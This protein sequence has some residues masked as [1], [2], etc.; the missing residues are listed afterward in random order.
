MYHGL[1][2]ATNKASAEERAAAPHH[3][4]DELDTDGPWTVIDFHRAAVQR[5]AAI[6][7][8]GKTPVLVGGTHYYLE[9]LLF[10]TLVAA[11]GE[12][13]GEGEG[14]GGGEGGR[15]IVQA[16]AEEARAPPAHPALLRTAEDAT[17][18]AQALHE[19]LAAVDPPMAKRLHPNN[20]RKVRRSLEIY[21][22]GGVPHSTVLASQAAGGPRLRHRPL[23]CF[24]LDTERDILDRRLDG[25]V[26]AM[27]E[28][29]LLHE[30][31]AFYVNVIQR[32]P[33]ALMQ[34][35][36]SSGGSGNGGGDDNNSGCA[37]PAAAEEE[38]NRGEAGPGG[39]EGGADRQL[40]P[41]DY[42]RGILQAIGLKE[43]QPLF[44]WLAAHQ[45]PALCAALR[46][47]QPAQ[48]SPAAV[49]ADET[50]QALLA[51]PPARALVAG[52][53]EAVKSATRRYAR[54][55][56]KWI[57]GRLRQGTLWKAAKR[58]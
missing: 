53:I 10:E 6:E 15:G 31:L 51:E 24:W 40:P 45:W 58:R 28:Q 52:G 55:Q 41:L 54:R 5:L 2:I 42:T 19:A 36:G 26:D 12:G 30:L 8:R 57:T 47:E 9:S 7:Q 43:F 16:K 3:L 17:L 44:D 29:G 48:L 11:R 25:R 21:A 22:T 34:H 49:A 13:E 33:A 18:S 14:E 56:I 50:L 20:V 39:E 37:S 4:L 46:G 38:D 35:G 23:C 32:R 1:D 27:L